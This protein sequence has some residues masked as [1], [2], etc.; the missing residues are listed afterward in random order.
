MY[1]RSLLLELFVETDE[2]IR[3]IERRFAEIDSPNDF[4]SDDNGLD[5]PDGISMMLISI[6]RT[7]FEAEAETRILPLYMTS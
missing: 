5:R 4:I 7:I 3:R 6:L 2:A 1:D